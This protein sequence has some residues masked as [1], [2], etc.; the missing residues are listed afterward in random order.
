MPEPVMPPMI[1]YDFKRGIAHLR[2]P[3]QYITA[4]PTIVSEAQKVF[5]EKGL[6]QRSIDMHDVPGFTI[7][8]IVFK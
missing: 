6:Y 7:A 8:K 2:L 3:V 5:K 4:L 1:H